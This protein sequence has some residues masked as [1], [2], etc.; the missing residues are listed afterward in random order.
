ML[1]QEFLFRNNLHM[2][3]KCFLDHPLLAGL[4]QWNGFLLDLGNPNYLMRLE[5]LNFKMT[6]WP[7]DWYKWYNN[8]DLMDYVQ[9]ERYESMSA[10][11]QILR[12][13]DVFGLGLPSVT[14]FLHD[15]MEW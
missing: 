7:H 13:S 1:K 12:K 10:S 8:I 14:N 5:G 15:P 11:N 9:S 2:V 3:K 6:W 4:M